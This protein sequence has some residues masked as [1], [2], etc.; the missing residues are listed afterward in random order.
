MVDDQRS[1]SF[2][3]DVSLGTLQ[4][5]SKIRK[6]FRLL[7]AG[8]AGDR[9]LDISIRSLP[10][11]STTSQGV[12]PPIHSTETLRTLTV[13][14][15]HPF[16]HAFDTHVY[17]RRKAVKALLDMSESTGWEAASDASI[18]ARLHA[19]GPWELDVLSIDL[20]VEVSAVLAH[21]RNSV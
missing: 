6:T 16:N 12:D 7:C 19:A 11:T 2:I 4:P 1:A 10:A 17:H 21:L 3:R 9:P 13:T 18:V 8:S 15:V 20:D 14:A 5:G